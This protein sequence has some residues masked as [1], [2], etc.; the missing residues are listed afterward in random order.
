M[1]VVENKESRRRGDVPDFRVNPIYLMW[2]QEVRFRR[3]NGDG[4]ATCEAVGPI[5][6]L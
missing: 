1:C 2:Q 4:P 3:Q 5:T 6:M